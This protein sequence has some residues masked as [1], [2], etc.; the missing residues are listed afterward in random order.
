MHGAFNRAS[1]MRE[2]TSETSPQCPRAPGHGDERIAQFQHL[3]LA[4]RHV[5]RDDELDHTFQLKL[6]LHKHLRLHADDQPAR[7][8]GG[9][10]E[11]AHQAGSRAAVHQGMAVFDDPGSQICGGLRER[12][13][14]PWLAPRYTVMFIEAPSGRVEVVFGGG[15]KQRAFAPTI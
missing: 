7:F 5:L 8:Q 12:R 13:A 14:V 11:H 4:L 6:A 2:M 3:R 10:G 1:A 15:A 9:S